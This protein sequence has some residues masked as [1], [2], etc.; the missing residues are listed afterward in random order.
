[1]AVIAVDCGGTNL[2]FGRAESPATIEVA[3]RVPTP[4]EVAAIPAAVVEAVRPLVDRSVRAIGVG[5]AGLV[6]HAA[7]SLV[8]SPH[9]QGGPVRLGAE[10]S[11]S[12]GL[13][14][15]V[16]ND[17]NLAA[18]AEA[19][20]GAGAGYRMV[21]LV[22]LGTGIGGGLVVGGAVERGRAFLGEAGHMIVDPSGPACA[23]GRFG[24]W[25]ALVSGTSLGRAARAIA[26]A[27]P[28]GAVARAAAGGTPRGEH[29]SAAA[30]EGDPRARAA[31]AEAGG[32]LGRGLANLVVLLDPDVIVVG[33]GAAAAGEALLGP[34]RATLAAAV[35]GAGYRAPTPVVAARFGSRA[36]LVG[37][38][39]EAEEA[40]W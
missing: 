27:D 9:S 4:R 39:L 10:V 20:L 30:G 28:A 40:R 31:L 21:L 12:T 38:A 5:S 29:L 35:G 23:C 22:A 17:A 32:W 37:A 7:G 13:P 2:I 11:T 6:D 14:V 36:G 26:D 34:A 16:D 24:C 1:L 19:R 18:L 33:G 8:C 25:E 15:V 3:G